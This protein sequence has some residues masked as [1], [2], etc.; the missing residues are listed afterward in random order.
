[1]KIKEKKENIFRITPDDL[2]EVV[3]WDPALAMN[4]SF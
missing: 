4:P 2:A 1:M 3:T